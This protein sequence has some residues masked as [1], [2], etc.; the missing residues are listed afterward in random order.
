MTGPGPVDPG[1]LLVIAREAA[2][3]AARLV[4][5]DRPRGPLEVTATKSSA[6]DIVTV[7]D[8][9]SERAIVEHISAARPDDGFLGEEGAA[10]E[11][12]TGVTWVIDPIDGTVNYLYEIPAYAVS[13]AAS[14]AGRVVAGAVV[15]PA[16]GETWTAARGEGAW[17]DG[18]PIRVNTAPEPAMALVATG[19]G[20]EPARR[21]RQADILRAVLPRVRDV[22]RFGAAS[23]DLCALACGR[24]DAY[25]EQGLKPWDLAAG[26]LVAEE[27]GAVVGG[28][29]GRPAGE[30]LVV[31]APPGLYEPLSEL[32]S[33]LDADAQ[34]AD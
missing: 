13:V 5:D 2:A 11:G 17:L 18:R 12:T 16:S 27:A 4:V 30:A 3:V 9:R 7:M 32:L 25:Y 34:V 23:L 29:H 33:E 8:Q 21:A 15:N 1:A 14:V 6:T 10:R 20:Y 28:L 22:R 24:V 26:G 31:A 19:F